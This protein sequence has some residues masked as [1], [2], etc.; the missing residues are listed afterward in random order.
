MWC[1]WYHIDLI[2]KFL[3][4]QISTENILFIISSIP[5]FLESQTTRLLLVPFEK[6][7]DNF[8]FKHVEERLSLS[9]IIRLIYHINAYVL[10]LSAPHLTQ[11]K[12]NKKIRR[13]IDMITYSSKFLHLFLEQHVWTQ[14]CSVVFIV[15]SNDG[16]HPWRCR[17]NITTRLLSMWY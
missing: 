15:R 10:S 5:I 1:K 4:H 11:S 14:Y 7:K 3:N 6:G 13:S 2:I 8:Y 9:D 12:K 17:Q 16:Q